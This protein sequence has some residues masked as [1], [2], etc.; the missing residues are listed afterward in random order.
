MGAL[1]ALFRFYW[2]VFVGGG[3]LMALEIIS[4]RMLSPHFGSSVYVWG[5]I[6]STFLAALSLGYSIGGRLADRYPHLSALGRLLVAAAGCQ[7]LL[8]LTGESLVAWLGE[9]TGGSPAGTLLTTAVLF[10][11]LT[12]LLGMVSPWAI[13]IAAHDLDDLGHTAGRL[14]AVSTAGSLVGTLAATFLLIPYL[15]LG[16]ILGILLGLTAIT[17][18][19]ALIEAPRR[20][21]LPI[22]LAALLVVLVVT[23]IRPVTS[24]DDV[25]YRRITPYQTLEIVERGGSRFLVSDNTLQAGIRLDDGSPALS[26]ARLMPVAGLLKEDLETALLLGMGAGNSAYML[27]RV[28]PDLEVDYVDIDPAV[29]QVAT[30][31]MRFEAGPN[32]RIHIRD[33]R[34]FLATTDRQWDFILIDTYIGRSVPFHLTTTEFFGLVK[35]K[36]T[37]DGVLALNLASGLD[38]PFPKAIARTL[39]DHFQ[40]V[41]AFKAPGLANVELFATRDGSPMGADEMLGRARELD[42]RVALE[43]S[44]TEIVE[45]QL[46]E[47]DVELQEAPLLTDAFAPVERLVVISTAELPTAEADS[48]PASGSEPNAGRAP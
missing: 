23:R 6:I 7:A 29:P 37:Q 22:A 30:R 39:S 2:L 44:A 10:G 13:R 24:F 28:F 43:L 4:S 31:F 45:S 48:L 25:T 16:Q 41:Y 35:S 32:D 5:S 21:A 3:V 12:V 33:A 18:A 8:L 36:L 46:L 40:P 15:Q 11:P 26:Y 38:Q 19:L 47:L 17:G 34:R 27:R 20:E 42:L 14:Y 9:A 1:M